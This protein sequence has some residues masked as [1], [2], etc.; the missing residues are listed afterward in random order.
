MSG[1]ATNYDA[2]LQAGVMEGGLRFVV[3]THAE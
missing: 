3:L 2:R 1:S